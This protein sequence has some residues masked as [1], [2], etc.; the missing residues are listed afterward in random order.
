[1]SKPIETAYVKLG[2]TVPSAM[3]TPL[4]QPVLSHVSSLE[5]IFN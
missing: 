3:L 4:W 2:L 5:L 1:M